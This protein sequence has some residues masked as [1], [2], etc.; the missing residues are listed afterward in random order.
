MKT[1]D[2]IAWVFVAIGL[3]PIAGKT[4]FAAWRLVSR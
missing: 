1:P 4:L 3:L 2:V